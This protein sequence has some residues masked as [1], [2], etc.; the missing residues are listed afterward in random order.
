MPKGETKVWAVY[1]KD[2][3]LKKLVEAKT[4]G[5]VKEHLLD[6]TTIEEASALTVAR[7]GM[8]TEKA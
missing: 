2:G 4:R 3:E 8:T 1:D 5:Q 6:G 7:S